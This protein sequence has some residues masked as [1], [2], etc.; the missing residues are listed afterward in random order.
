M[1]IKQRRNFFELFTVFSNLYS[2]K[3]KII[4]KIK[5]RI[6]FIIFEVEFVKK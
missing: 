6:I 5:L 4:N 2:D 1:E 3:L